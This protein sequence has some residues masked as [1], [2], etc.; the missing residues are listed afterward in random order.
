[1]VVGTAAYDHLTDTF[2]TYYQFT[3][4]AIAVTLA[5]VAAIPLRLMLLFRLFPLLAIDE[6]QELE[7]T[8]TEQAAEPSSSPSA[9]PRGRATSSAGWCW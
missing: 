3:W 8:G 4:V 6:I 5:G 7:A 9:A 2:G 1:M